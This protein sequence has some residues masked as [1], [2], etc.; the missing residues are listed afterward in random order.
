[1]WEGIVVTYAAA[2]LDEGY[3]RVVLAIVGSNEL[4]ARTDAYLEAGVPLREDA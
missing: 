4:V 1:M 3:E 2:G